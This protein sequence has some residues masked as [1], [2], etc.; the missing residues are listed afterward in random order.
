M[1]AAI[2]LRSQLKPDQVEKITVYTY[3][4]A[5]RGHDHT[6]ISGTP[7]AKLS[8]PYSVAAALYTGRGDTDIYEEPYISDSEILALTRCIAVEEKTE[9]TR[10]NP[11]KRIAELEILLKDG[12]RLTRRID[13][14]KGDPENPMSRQEII[15]KA[16]A[17]VGSDQVQQLINKI[18]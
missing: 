12:S 1:E 13:Y 11:Q 6:E 4:L 14:A 2:A 16:T 3:Q 7:S 15:E 5:V 17:L 8:I 10:E 18:Y 9:Y